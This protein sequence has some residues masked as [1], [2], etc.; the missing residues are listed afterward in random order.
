MATQQYCQVC[1]F[2][3][4]G[5]QCAR[6]SP[7]P[8]VNQGPPMPA[9]VRTIPGVQ[10]SWQCSR[11]RSVI[12]NHITAC[13]RCV[14]STLGPPAQQSTWSCECGYSHNRLSA[15]GYCRRPKPAAANIEYQ[16]HWTCAHCH[17]LNICM[18]KYCNS[19]GRAWGSVPTIETLQVQCTLQVCANGWVC[20]FCRC[21]RNGPASNSCQQ[22]QGLNAV[23]RL[24][25]MR[26]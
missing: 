2:L 21:D 14:A 1:C 20:E 6:C 8:Y 5:S 16:T 26:R 13:S 12:P 11:C 4:S 23:G 9:I 18:N 15:C 22:C 10:S 25:S 24:L 3:Y 7:V 17:T 19:C